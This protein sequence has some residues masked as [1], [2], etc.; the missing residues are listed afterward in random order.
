MQAVRGSRARIVCALAAVAAFCA[1]LPLSAGAKEKGFKFGVTA[2]DVHTDS[3]LLW[4]R[5]NSPGK[6]VL[7]LRREGRKLGACKPHKGSAV[8]RLKSK[9]KNDLT[10]QRRIGGLKPATSY[11]YRFCRKGGRHSN[12]GHFGTPPA[13][14][15]NETIR[16]A[17]SGDQDARPTP[18]E[19]QPYWNDFQI[20]DR[21]RAQKN[22]FNV[23]M[24][25]TIYS[26]TEV[27]GYGIKDVAVSLQQKWDAY[28]LNLGQKPWTKTRGATS[29][30]AH[31][32]D[33]EFIND[34]SRHEN[35][36]PYSNDG[37]FKGNT[38]IDGVKLYKRGVRAFRDYNPVTYSRKNGIYRSQ[39][40]GKNLE[41]FFLD[42][43]SFRS[44]SA[45]YDGSCDNPQNSGNPDL[46]PT[47]PQST[48]NV[49]SAIVPQLANPAPKK[50]IRKIN[51]KDRTMLGDRQLSQ[52][53]RAVKNS[54]ATFKV[55]FNEVP[56]QQFYALPYDRWEGYEYERKN[57][58]RFLK[59]NVDNAVFMTTD[60]HANLVNDA[61]LNTL[62][63]GGVKNSGILDVTTGPVATESYSG[64]INAA[65]GNPQ[66][67]TLV[68]N[69]FFK[70][71]P[72]QGVG[73]QCAATDV[74]SYAETKVTASKLTID[75]LDASDDPVQDTG[76]SEQPGPPCNRIV[77][78]A[79]G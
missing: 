48:R 9:R 33:H 4:A 6:V 72:P 24:G 41:V 27:P 54:D 21:I 17:L 63:D 7:Q 44:K 30:Y 35:K 70:P 57:L 77:I 22:D 5:P 62:G 66:A 69:L 10:V 3:A 75:L 23:L 42:E 73:M 79:S 46:A 56:I 16:F 50:C 11:R 26:D 18:G 20:W 43:R 40:W 12:V 49:F 51:N 31:W 47:A 65:V 19:S 52:F 68:H 29:Y 64:E 71:P 53:K 39:Q 37:E 32:D 58:L 67:G 45:D 60:V 25:D 34:F 8:A 36:F 78:N 55:I 38:K 74:F 28:K 15:Q 13:P 59:K 61:R 76:D 2:A 14:R 1:L